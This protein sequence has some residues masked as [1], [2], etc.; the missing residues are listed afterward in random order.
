MTPYGAVITNMAQWW[1]RGENFKYWRPKK[2]SVSQFMILLLQERLKEDFNVIKPGCVLIG[3]KG[4]MVIPG[5]ECT[6][7]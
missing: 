1:R 4:Q 7:N 5:A 3:W 6:A 2:I